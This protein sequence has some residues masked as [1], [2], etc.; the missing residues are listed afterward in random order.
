M[1]TAVRSTPSL[2]ITPTQNTAPV[3]EFR[4][5]Y[6][7]DLRKKKKV[8]HDGSLRF[9][10]F[11]RRVM[12]YDDSKNYIG[13]THW[14]EVGDFHEGEELK[15]DKGVM[16]EVGEQ[17]GRTETD[18][19]P[20][21]LEKRRPEPESSPPRVTLP[22]HTY[23][24]GPR[25]AG[26]SSAG[27][28]KSLAAVLGASQ[29]RIGRARLPARSPFEQRQ[30]SIQQQ[31]ETGEPRAT[32]RPR[33]TTKKA[34]VENELHSLN[35]IGQTHFPEAH[36]PGTVNVKG[37]LPRRQMSLAPMESSAGSI[38]RTPLVPS[39]LRSKGQGR[40]QLEAISAADCIRSPTPS[41]L[42]AAARSGKETFE[43]C[44]SS[45][46]ASDHISKQ[47]TSEGCLSV[48]SMNTNHV[49]RLVG[50][51]AASIR[52]AGGAATNKLRFAKEKP[53]RKL[54]YTELLPRARQKRGS[55]CVD[56]N[57][58]ASKRDKQK[59]KRALQ[60]SKEWGESLPQGNITVDLL[61]EAEDDMPM[62]MQ[63]PIG[64]SMGRTRQETPSLSQSLPPP[65]SPLFENEPRHSAGLTHSQL[66]L[67]EDFEPP[68]RPKLPRQGVIHCQR[69]D[70]V[71]G[72]Q[73][74]PQ[75][76]VT[77]DEVTAAANHEATVANVVPQR[78]SK[79]TALDQ[80][81]LQKFG[82]QPSPKQR[83][84]RRILSEGD[85]QIHRRTEV[86]VY[87][88]GIP[89]DTA[90][91]TGCVPQ[92]LYQPENPMK[93]PTKVQ[94]SVSDVTHLAQRTEVPRRRPPISPAVEACFDPWSEL[95]SYL[96]FDWWPPG[97][98]KP[99]FVIS[100]S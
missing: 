2:T 46:T 99:S 5:L 6:T 24:S 71:P 89:C 35:P 15:L 50:D 64:K 78:P 12:V 11:N 43:N 27:R 54:I 51:P 16:V 97:K 41:T 8:W 25:P 40:S 21:I 96:L 33:I 23:S 91:T 88:I 13:D 63:T 92:S 42:S 1:T 82:L 31:L 79:L 38:D 36:V 37:N 100:D 56:E 32:K 68:V 74:G 62:V 55:S 52:S 9:H 73:G 58:C 76:D 61:S 44:M 19:A 28:P 26:I 86:E 22:S 59:R 80:R 70:V 7:H 83:P 53:R 72:S 49:N 84:F 29:G 65:S 10:T 4:C 81:L 94:R 34:D 75:K 57:G 60:M 93:S 17:I 18:L 98:R 77:G 90:V 20:V 45:G 87:P 14:R 95:E 47:R 30:D 66:S 3:F 39:R 69:T 85:S 67:E 48:Q